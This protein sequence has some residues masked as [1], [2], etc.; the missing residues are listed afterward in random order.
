M[1]TDIFAQ[2]NALTDGFVIPDGGDSAVIGKEDIHQAVSTLNRYRAGKANFDRRIVEAEK[3]FRQQHWQ[4]LRDGKI[5]QTGW[6]FSAIANKHADFMDN[7]P[8]VTVSAREPGDEGAA[9]ALTAVIPVVLDRAEWKKTYSEACYEKIKKGTAVYMVGW[10]PNAANGLG[11]VAVRTIDGLN[12]FWE[13]GIEDIQDSANVF[14]VELMSHD[15]IKAAYPDKAELQNLS[16]PSLTVARYSFDEDID[17]SD[18]SYVVNWYYKRRIGDKT[19][20]HYCRFV[21]DI[22]LYASENDPTRRDSG[23]YTHGLY[24]FV[25]DVFFPDKGT[26]AGFGLIDISKDTQE[27]IDTV[28]AL[29]VDCLK[30][31]ARV[32]YFMRDGAAV[33]AEEYCDLDKDIVHVAGNLDEKDIREINRPDISGNFITLQQYKIAEMKENTFNRDVNSGG[34]G[35]TTTAAGIGALQEAGSKVSRDIIAHTYHAFKQICNM[36][37]E[38]IR[39]FYDVPRYF[40]ILGEDKVARYTAFDNS[41]LQPRPVEPEFGVDFGV[42]EPVFDLNVKVAKSNTW[43]KAAQNQDIINFYGM[44]FFNPEQSTQALACLSVLEI[45]NKDEL[46]D[47]IK[48]NSLKEQFAVQFL[49]LLLNMA[50]V[51]APDIGIQ[52]MQAAAAAGLIDPNAVMPGASPSAPNDGYNNSSSEPSAASAQNKTAQTDINGGIKRSSAYMDKQTDI[53]RGRTAPR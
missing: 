15:A 14:T 18:K 32:R 36:I 25:F 50:N 44:G 30:R 43:S 3:W 41:A 31:G 27:D 9:K 48:K 21:Q 52:A 19:V 34:T 23:W 24:P 17:T 40:R 51:Y 33:N 49:P 20:L 12:I 11:D 37:I 16:A 8:D 6:L 35:G 4:G 39:Q 22:V 28:N 42:K 26:P 2:D 7:F 13:P 1:D 46:I 38:L 29:M 10:D 47:I 53:A 45:D 5:R